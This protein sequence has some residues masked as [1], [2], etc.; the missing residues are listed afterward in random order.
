MSLFCM[1]LFHGSFMV[2]F[3]DSYM[4]FSILLLIK[5]NVCFCLNYFVIRILKVLIYIFIYLYACDF[6]KISKQKICF[7]RKK[8]NQIIKLDI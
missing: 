2:L 5:C 1:V 4:M 8:L 6:K 3:H 7:T